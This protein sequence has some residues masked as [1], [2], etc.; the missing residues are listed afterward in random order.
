M[1]EQVENE[2]DSL[3]PPES[4]NFKAGPQPWKQGLTG[5]SVALVAALGRLASHFR[6]VRIHASQT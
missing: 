1:L 5:F 2:L 4:S 3:D 6:K